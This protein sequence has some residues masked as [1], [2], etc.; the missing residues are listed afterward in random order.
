MHNFISYGDYVYVTFP[1]KREDS[2]HYLHGKS[3]LDPKA[4]S[5]PSKS[6]LKNG[7][8]NCIFQIFPRDCQFLVDTLNES[9]KA[10]DNFQTEWKI[11]LE[12]G[13]QR[14]VG[15]PVLYGD[16]VHLLHIETRSFL[17]YEIIKN[18]ENSI[19]TSKLHLIQDMSQEKT[20]FQL[21]T[22]S[23][24]FYP[25]ER[26]TYKTNILFKHSTTCH[27]LTFLT[28]DRKGSFK[29]EDSDSSFQAEPV[30]ELSMNPLPMTLV[31]ISPYSDPKASKHFREANYILNGDF[32]RIYDSRLI[33][34]N[35]KVHKFYLEP[36]G[37]F[38]SEED[39]VVLHYYNINENTT[40]S[41]KTQTNF[42]SHS[43]S[44]LNVFQIINPDELEKPETAIK[45]L[46]KI[47][48]IDSKSLMRNKKPYLIKHLASSSFILNPG[49]IETQLDVKLDLSHQEGDD[50]VDRYR[51]SLFKVTGK[52]GSLIVNS[53]F[54]IGDYSAIK[55]D[56][57]YIAQ[58]TEEDP[59]RVVKTIALMDKASTP[60]L[61]MRY[62]KD[63]R[64]LAE[65]YSTFSLRWDK[66]SNMSESLRCE[67]VSEDELYD[68]NFFI[69]SS[70]L[71]NY[72][73]AELESFRKTAQKEYTNCFPYLQ[74]TVERIKDVTIKILLFVGDRRLE[75]DYVHDEN[76]IPTQLKQT[77]LREFRIIETLN[78]IILKL[79]LIANYYQELPITSDSK[80][81]ELIVHLTYLLKLYM[82]KNPANTNDL[83]NSLKIYL[84]PELMQ[85]MT[86]IV[87]EV[88]NYS[89]FASLN[90]IM[91]ILK[92]FIYDKSSNNY[93]KYSPH[94][95]LS[96]KVLN[97]LIS[98]AKFKSFCIALQRYRNFWSPQFIISV[99]PK[100][101]V[102]HETNVLEVHYKDN[103]LMKLTDIKSESIMSVES[104][105]VLN[106]LDLITIL[107]KKLPNFQRLYTALIDYLPYEVCLA[108][109]Q[110]SD[111]ETYSFTLKK[112]M[113][114]LIVHFHFRHLLSQS[115]F[116][117]N[118]FIKVCNVNLPTF[119]DIET[120]EQMFQSTNSLPEKLTLINIYNLYNKKLQSLLSGE[121]IRDKQIQKEILDVLQFSAIF[122]KNNIIE[123][124]DKKPF[125]ILYQ[126]YS[127]LKKKLEETTGQDGK[128]I[129]DDE[130]LI[131]KIR[132]QF[133]EIQ[134]YINQA[135]ET[136]FAR[137]YLLFI[138]FKYTFNE[139]NQTTTALQ[140]LQA[141]LM[142]S[143]TVEVSS[144][145]ETSLGKLTKRPSDKNIG[146]NYQKKPSLS[147]FIN[148]ATKVDD[149]IEL[150]LENYKFENDLKDFLS[151][152][153]ASLEHYSLS[154]KQI[155]NSQLNYINDDD[156]MDFQDI[157]SLEKLSSRFKILSHH[158]KD[159]VMLENNSEVTEVI[160]MFDSI[161][162]VSDKIES[163]AKG[164]SISEE[165]FNTAEIQ[166]Q[167][168]LKQFGID[169][170]VI[171]EAEVTSDD[172]L[173][174]LL[175]NPS[176]FDISYHIHNFEKT[177]NN[178]Q[179]FQD[180]MRIL[181]IYD[182]LLDILDYFVTSTNEYYMPRTLKCRLYVVQLLLFFILNNPTNCKAL[183]KLL[184]T[185]Y[186]YEVYS[187]KTYTPD[188][189]V[190]MQILISS[191]FKHSPDL[192]MN[193]SEVK[194]LIQIF[195]EPYLRHVVELNDKYPTTFPASPCKSSN[196]TTFQFNLRGLN[197][198]TSNNSNEN[199]SHGNGNI[200]GNAGIT[201][202]VPVTR[203]TTLLKIPEVGQGQSLI[204]KMSP[205]KYQ[206]S[207][208]MCSFTL[209]SI[210]AFYK[211]S[212]K[213][214][215]ARFQGYLQ[216]LFYLNSEVF[217]HYVG[218]TEKY[219]FESEEYE[220][221]W[222]RFYQNLLK[223]C[224]EFATI[225]PAMQE[226]LLSTF[227]IMS[228]LNDIILKI[229]K[230]CP[231]SLKVQLIHL[232]TLLF[233]S[234]QNTE[235]NSKAKMEFMFILIFEVY[236]YVEFQLF[237]ANAEQKQ[238]I[239]DTFLKTRS[240][241]IWEDITK[242]YGVDLMQVLDAVI[243]EPSRL[244]IFDDVQDQ[245]QQNVFGNILKFFKHL[246]KY[247]PPFCLTPLETLP[248]PSSV[249]L[250]D[251][252]MGVLSEVLAI[253]KV[254]GQQGKVAHIKDNLLN[255]V[256]SNKD[257]GKFHHQMKV[258]DFLLTFETP[259]LIGGEEA[260]AVSL[261]NVS[262]IFETT[263]DRFLSEE[264]VK[265]L[266]NDSLMLLVE[267]VEMHEM[268][269]KILRHLLTIVQSGQCDNLNKD[270]HTFFCLL[271]KELIKNKISKL[272]DKVT[273]FE[274]LMPHVKLIQKTFYQ[275]DFTRF[276]FK[277]MVECSENSLLLFLELSTL[278]LYGGYDKI[279][280][281]F[282][283]CFMTDHE[284]RLML[285]LSAQFKKISE[286]FIRKEKI[287]NTANQM[288]LIKRKLKNDHLKH[289]DDS[290]TLLLS[291]I[292]RF[293]NL[294][295]ENHNSEFQQ[296]F[297]E[298]SHEK[299]LNSISINFPIELCQ[300]VN[301]YVEV[302]NYYSY[303]IGHQLLNALIEI[304]QGD[305][306]NIIHEICNRTKIVNDLLR[307]LTKY[308]PGSA[309]YKGRRFDGNHVLESLKS[310]AITLLL[311]IVESSD[312]V[313]KNIIAEQID[314]MMLIKATL[315]YTDMFFKKQKIEIGDDTDALLRIRDEEFVAE[316]GLAGGLNLL[317]LIKILQGSSSV[318]RLNMTNIIQDCDEAL[319]DGFQYYMKELGGKFIQSI[320][321]LDKNK[322]LRKIYFSKLPSCFYLDSSIKDE[323]IERIDRSAYHV[324]ISE[325]MA[326]AMEMSY[327]MRSQ[328][329]I[330][331]NPRFTTI[332]QY[333]PKLK[334]YSYAMAYLINILIMLYFENEDL[335]I[336]YADSY[337]TW[338]SYFY[339]FLN[340][341]Q[342]IMSIFILILWFGT[343]EPKFYLAV[344]WV[345]YTRTN[346]KK[347]EPITY[348]EEYRW[349]LKP[350]SI[351][352]AE[353]IRIL[354]LKGPNASELID[355]VGK[356]FSI[357]EIQYIYLKKTLTFLFKSKTFLNNL[358][359]VIN[360]WLSLVVHPIF[361]SLQLLNSLAESGIMQGVISSFYKNAKELGITLG[362][363]VIIVFIYS[364]V[365]FFFLR[366]SFVVEDYENICTSIWH[367]FIS[368]LNFGMRSGGGIGDVLAQES[369]LQGRTK[370]YAGRWFYDISFFFLIVVVML[371]LVFGIVIDT[372]SNIRS[373]KIE[374]E[375]D[376]TGKCFIC[377]I[378]RGMLER[379]GSGFERHSL[380]E[381]HMWN[382]IFYIVHLKL[383]GV[384][385]L[386][387]IEDYVYRCYKNKD[388]SWIPYKRA[389]CMKGKT[390][391]EDDL[392]VEVDEIKIKVN[393]IESK[394]DKLIGELLDKKDKKGH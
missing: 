351:T 335:D 60:E 217:S 319:R 168:V 171:E 95:E 182:R 345:G 307:L 150:T 16:S 255:E 71:L 118:E 298:Q 285:K 388:Y 174:F 314:Y 26:I 236:L 268:S 173:N 369:Y 39:S 245:L 157:V 43:L 206:T 300:F 242:N 324:K 126:G 211:T 337:S 28:S 361:C 320:E 15:S 304:V 282:F 172:I 342:L 262:T 24:Y 386:S 297:K 327:K 81:E 141:S 72:L 14:H 293:I 109:I 218:E 125:L 202:N 244:A 383:K 63:E 132:S 258:V 205:L 317:I 184:V 68:L 231:Y 349:H 188:V 280:K 276:L 156:V 305:S 108:V 207:L 227:G 197:L 261:A 254:Q 59:D 389:L 353:Y 259:A 219:K 371:N 166:L 212:S 21:E 284:N 274:F 198:N 148:S 322:T 147:V 372:F 99:F 167:Q 199:L 175:E 152:W 292:L 273:D 129:D 384:I 281:G 243:A 294:L 216:D 161:K 89:E 80:F 160:K 301:S 267:C 67:R 66:E 343:N 170:T 359:Y 272:E 381:H 387:E 85:R 295:C 164:N 196:P 340:F 325:F 288:L 257:Y 210:E 137:E 79:S 57:L 339:V 17:S 358:C 29:L 2:T 230:N 61:N 195:F 1:Q 10:K 93:T 120:P 326:D 128:Q 377:D 203:A 142:H 11:L 41:N 191:M 55:N 373:E 380:H 106:T 286:R 181:K 312:S 3:I 18:N 40:S 100:F 91:E 78:G 215:L 35:L 65:N 192:L 346:S 394:L 378:D 186:F 376:Q 82:M 54:L 252:L 332:T 306:R 275:Y 318:F 12:E 362:G 328:M 330:S 334:F 228:K 226:H 64:V 287:R 124:Q 143:R 360:C 131:S 13:I 50:N 32:V 248:G 8:R 392:D 104:K 348:E 341:I 94:S 266:E 153:D 49:T 238:Q 256:R 336:I 38:M 279:Q 34:E 263:I 331:L 116:W 122:F 246:F 62:Y 204:E 382:Y 237:K 76:F 127:N 114:D 37:N 151:A 146:Y 83:M 86:S 92:L 36:K 278:L 367:C 165:V 385:N 316:G 194:R 251:I 46:Q 119:P 56:I 138:R 33:R 84:R 311:S 356:A 105:Y 223:S 357:P 354:K 31:Q 113:L 145:G 224:S 58:S 249:P 185:A 201:L 250:I 220:S 158:L 308:Q 70:Q 289:R 368:M 154:L 271:M 22:V 88:L 110:Y 121:R 139:G 296:F 269:E 270:S 5:I 112:L 363:C 329:D 229:K 123:F 87:T 303:T 213:P 20:C 338:N 101:L 177:N 189:V 136:F 134:I 44:A 162:Q 135:I 117:P 19:Q 283:D 232:G 47:S 4:A 27:Y 48:Y 42:S 365:G 352:I 190:Y 264:N 155:I 233:S 234:F 30:V 130:S 98:V 260:V 178:G 290:E 102:N 111:S 253:S 370:I 208:I 9:Q 69:N 149:F 323:I 393:K 53:N 77:Y 291:N 74:Q 375:E 350:E 313:T 302:C 7:F 374:D 333:Y 321:I 390:G 45:I 247:N 103:L 239:R 391:G 90:L 187:G 364:L 355:P 221:I 183:H 379:V 310:D 347:S 309:L 222:L 140:H 52:E 240:L 97:I 200:N 344:K 163:N 107:A 25:G 209:N 159:F 214:L 75:G 277:N 366:D 115:L 144:R 225:S 265:I 180:A 96:V 51:V 73:N 133:K 241:A 179:K 193:D 235:E 176:V 23:N 315:N 169:T 299:K 6:L